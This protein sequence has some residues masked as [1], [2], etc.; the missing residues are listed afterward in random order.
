MKNIIK[1]LCFA[2]CVVVIVNECFA[3][4]DFNRLYSQSES[5]SLLIWDD[6]VKLKSNIKQVEK[7][8]EFEM[9][10]NS[11]TKSIQDSNNEKNEEFSF[12]AFELTTDDDWISEIS[13]NFSK[14]SQ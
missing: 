5:S 4:E 10:L 8:K 14:T 12:F 1:L 11:F 7:V 9:P 6:A 2:V 13:E 3:S